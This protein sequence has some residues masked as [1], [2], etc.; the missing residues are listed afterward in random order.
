MANWIPATFGLIGVIVG[1]L[2]NGSVTAYTD[3]RRNEHAGRSAAKLVL[4]EVTTTA[5][6]ANGAIEGECYGPEANTGFPRGEWMENRVLLANALGDGAWSCHRC[7]LL[8]IAQV[9]K[10]WRQS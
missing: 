7:T 5:M 1:G 2:L 8:S 10:V 6:M 4:E 3:R 9:A